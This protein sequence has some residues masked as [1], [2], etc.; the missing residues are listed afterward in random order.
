MHFA[1][2]GFGA[3]YVAVAC[4][5]AKQE[6]EELKQ[7]EKQK[8]IFGDKEFVYDSNGMQIVTRDRQPFR[9]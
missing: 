6:K 2:R 9:D 3:E 4:P 5:K 7:K 8:K 1:V